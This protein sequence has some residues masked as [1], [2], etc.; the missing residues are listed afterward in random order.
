MNIHPCMDLLN[1]HDANF[2]S[3]NF[4]NITIIIQKTLMLSI[5]CTFHQFLHELPNQIGTYYLFL[6]EEFNFD[7]LGNTSPVHVHVILVPNKTVHGGKF[8][9]EYAPCMHGYYVLKSNWSELLIKAR[10]DLTYV[11]NTCKTPD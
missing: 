5:Q 9:N 8:E 6:R 1:V 4:A 11:Y 10:I 2:I 7:G 3:S